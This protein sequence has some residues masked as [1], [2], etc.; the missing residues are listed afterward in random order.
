MKDKIKT[1]DI[2]E[3][4]NSLAVMAMT[5]L[6]DNNLWQCYGYSKRPKHGSVFEKLFPDKFELENYITKEVLTMGLIDVFNGIKKSSKTPEDKI[7]MSMG[8]IDIF[9]FTTKHLYSYDSFLEHLF[10]AYDD[11]LKSDKDKLHISSLLKAREVLDKKN[12]AKYL[13]GTTMI[14]SHDTHTEDFL[15]NSERVKELIDDTSLDGKLKISMPKEILDKY[16]HLISTK[17][18]NNYKTK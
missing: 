9:L 14:F 3:L 12:S 5:P 4:A 2:N 15:V 7:F 16:V 17:I 8:L 1:T 18:L 10:E 13:V 6:L 11:Y